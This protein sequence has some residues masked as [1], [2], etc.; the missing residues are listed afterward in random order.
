MS[1]LSRLL[2]KKEMGK[3]RTKP[4]YANATREERRDWFAHTPPW[5]R[6]ASIVVDAILDGITNKTLLEGF[7][8]DLDNK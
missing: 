4:V 7:R 1:I 6:I 8:T 3:N 2:G 5:D